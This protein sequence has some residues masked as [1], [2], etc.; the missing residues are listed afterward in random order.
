M[1]EHTPEERAAAAAEELAAEGF[2]VTA[3][4]VQ[5]RA[6][7]GMGVASPAARDWNAR[8]AHTRKVPP[9]PDSVAV[10]VQ[11]LW[12]EAIEAARAEHQAERDG[13][14]SQLKNVEDERDGALDEASGAQ[15]E[16]DRANAHISELEVIV[17]QIRGMTAEAERRAV[18]SEARAAAAEGVAV[19][20]REA[21]TALSPKTMN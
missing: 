18:A 4:A 7:V 12:R 10:R 5:Q 1:A 8:Q 21:L 11:G 20:L 14:A 19:G 17:E 6:Q 9:L 16:L 15:Q 13:W 2:P 3:R